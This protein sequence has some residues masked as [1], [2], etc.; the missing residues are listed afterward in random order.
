MKNKSWALVSFFYTR[1][2]MIAGV[3]L[4]LYFLSELTSYYT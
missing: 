1:V 4:N 2:F 3:H